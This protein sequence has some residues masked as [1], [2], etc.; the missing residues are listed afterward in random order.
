MF[1]S[2]AFCPELERSEGAGRGRGNCMSC[3]PVQE[4]DC[5]GVSFRD[6]PNDRQGRINCLHLIEWPVRGR[7][8]RIRPNE[9]QHQKVK[10]R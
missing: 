2:G 3:V 7:Q 4:L 10:F 5:E 9:P 1:Q 8:Q 6:S